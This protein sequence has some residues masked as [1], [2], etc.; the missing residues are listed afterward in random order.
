MFDKD[1]EILNPNKKKELVK[2]KQGKGNSWLTL[3]SSESALL[4]EYGQQT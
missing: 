4:K 2:H 3:I 1:N